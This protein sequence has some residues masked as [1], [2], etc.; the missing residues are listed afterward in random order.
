MKKGWSNKQIKELFDFV[1][2]RS[3][4]ISLLEC[5]KKFAEINKRNPLAVRNFYYKQVKILSRNEEL[6]KKL[7]ISIKNYSVKNFVPFSEKQKNDLVDKID[8]LVA[9]GQSVRRAC[10]TLANGNVEKMVRYQNKY[11]SL[12]K[13]TVI[14]FPAT[15]YSATKSKALNDD[16]IKSL[17][18][19]LVKLVKENAIKSSSEDLKLYLQQSEM[20]K[21][22]DFVILSQNQ[23]KVEKL[24]KEIADLKQKNSELY[25]KLTEYRLLYI[26][27]Q[28]QLSNTD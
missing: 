11:R 18:M 1:Q 8:N 28:N 7:N 20:Q 10:Q 15:N 13:C 9:S 25:K 19:G 6:A 4:T 27:T 26:S 23:S 16:E 22:K 24:E 21:R 5:F 2:A 14:N 12:R 17:F 3:K